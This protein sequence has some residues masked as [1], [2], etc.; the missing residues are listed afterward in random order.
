MDDL[1]HEEFLRTYSSGPSLFHAGNGARC[2]LFVEN[3]N[4]KELCRNG[5]GNE[6]NHLVL[7]AAQHENSRFLFINRVY[8]LMLVKISNSSPATR[9][10]HITLTEPRPP[11]ERMNRQQWNVGLFTLRSVSEHGILLMYYTR[12]WLVRVTSKMMGLEF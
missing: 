9:N 1:H 6:L 7:K 3:L 2:S 12:Q 5:L 10:K 4:E 8:L 11:K